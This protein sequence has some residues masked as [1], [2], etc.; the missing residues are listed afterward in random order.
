MYSI[1][2][3]YNIVMPIFGGGG[4]PMVPHPLNKSLP[5]LYGTCA[6]NKIPQKSGSGYTD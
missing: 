3:D 2:Y 1:V 5:L 6:F 4:D